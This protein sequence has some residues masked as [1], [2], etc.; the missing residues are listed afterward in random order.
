MNMRVLM[1]AVMLGACAG[2]GSACRARADDA[3]VIAAASVADRQ[4]TAPAR[5]TAC[6]L[7]SQE[8]MSRLL[9]GSVGPPAADERGNSTICTYTPAAGKGLTPYAQLKI[10]W[11]GGEAAMTGV[12]LAD[13]FMSKDAGFSIVDKIE[14]VGDEASMM[15]GG[16]MNVRRG[17]VVLTIDLRMQPRAKEKG[18]AIAK[19]A[20]ARIDERAK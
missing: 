6:S 16:L 12:K 7:I 11:N 4:T 18:I 2:A 20:L 8:D 19:A 1:A 9:G 15:I 17:E 5:P 14:G 3:G 13:R 10:D